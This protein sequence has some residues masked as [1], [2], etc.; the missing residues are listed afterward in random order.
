MIEVVSPRKLFAAQFALEKNKLT[1]LLEVVSHLDLQ[2]VFQTE[3]TDL[4]SIRA[5]LSVL[6][7]GLPHYPGLAS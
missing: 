3:L 1:L 2:N 7:H 5:R 6:W 4:K